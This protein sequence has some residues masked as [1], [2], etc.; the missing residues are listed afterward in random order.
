MSAISK[1]IK[2]KN[3]KKIQKN[4]GF[5]VPRTSKPEFKKT[6]KPAARSK[7]VRTGVPN[8]RPTSYNS[9]VIGHSEY[10][11]AVAAVQ[12]LFTTTVVEV[13]PGLALS[14]PWLSGVAHNYESYKFRK[15]VYRYVPSCPIS[16]AGSISMAVDY[17]VDDYT[18]SMKSQL[19]S[20]QGAVSGPVWDSLEFH[21]DIRNL[22]K[23]SLDHYVRAG[24][25]TGT[26]AKTY[27]VGFLTI[28]TDNMA[29]TLSVGDFYVDYEVELIT[30]QLQEDDDYRTS[31]KVLSA[32]STKANPLNGCTVE[33]EEYFP[34]IEANQ[35]TDEIIFKRAGKFLL[36]CQETGTGLTTTGFTFDEV[37]GHYMPTI[38]SI[39]VNLVNAALNTAFQ[40]YVVN[41]ETPGRFK[42]VSPAGWTTLGTL[43]L[44]IASYNL[45]YL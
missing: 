9:V 23:F 28:A 26:D 36:S 34:V 35:P 39:G 29:A 31:G 12:S 16:T 42:V 2:N 15:L 5:S 21:C 13:N 40:Q 20:F 37:V 24:T 30:P 4:G 22:K 3:M 45:V 19:M 14:F 18:P 32:A 38:T 17:D 41:V 6:T 1:K 27:D 33:T 25:I 10:V 8:I 44:R 11:G 7:I 43:A